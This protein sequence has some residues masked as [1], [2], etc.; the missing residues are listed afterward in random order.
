MPVLAPDGSGI[1][2]RVAEASAE[3]EAFVPWARTGAHAKNSRNETVIEAIRRH[4]L[5][6]Y[7]IIP[8]KESIRAFGIAQALTLFPNQK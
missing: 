1:E 6:K 3:S 2:A 7:K 4:I 5:R 8:G